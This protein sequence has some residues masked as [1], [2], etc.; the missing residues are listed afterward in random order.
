MEKNTVIAHGGLL[1]YKEAGATSHDAVNAVRRH[2][3][4]VSTADQRPKVGHSGTLDPFATGLLIILLGHATRLQDELHLLPKTY[5]A[6]ITLG[7]TSDTDDST[8]TLTKTNAPQQP[9]QKDVE[10]ALNFIK[11]QTEQIPPHYAAIKIKGKKMYEYAREG[12]V[13]ER[14]PRPVIIHEIILHAYNYPILDISVKCST[15]TY[16]RSIA[17]DIGT[18]LKTGGY[19]SRLSRTA[20]GAFSDTNGFLVKDLPSRLENVLISM[21]EL[22]NHIPQLV[23]PEDNVAKYKQGKEGVS[24]SN[25]PK[26]TPI[27]LLN[28]SKDLFGIGIRETSALTIKP[29]K[30]FL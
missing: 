16:I 8:G 18:L 1:V 7:A 25:M 29:K 21:A 3:A 19:C 24:P 28:E 4:T 2:I 9:T 17:R 26:N 23:C 6:E 13:V 10:A 20:I 30:I 27:A 22:T 5:R 15:G 14:E 11:Q 12:K